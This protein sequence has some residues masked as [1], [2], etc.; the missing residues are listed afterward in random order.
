[1]STALDLH[2][3][4]HGRFREAFGLPTNSLGPAEQWSIQPEP[5][6]MSIMI[7]LN[8]PIEATA[9][10]MLDPHDR[11]HDVETTSISHIGEVDPVIARIRARVVSARKNLRMEDDA[12]RFQQFIEAMRDW[13][14]S[15][16]ATRKELSDVNVVKMKMFG[17]LIAT[18]PQFAAAY[19]RLLG[20]CL[21]QDPEQANLGMSV[22]LKAFNEVSHRLESQVH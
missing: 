9:V 12:P 21:V 4:V 3:Q 5:G 14:A 6:A 8:G 18:S 19:H 16:V 2:H 11:S 20:T 10:W 17:A 15:T 13:C 7:F 1:M 22:F